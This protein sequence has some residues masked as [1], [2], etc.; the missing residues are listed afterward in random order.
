[1]ITKAEIAN[2]KG[3]DN[4][5]FYGKDGEIIDIKPYPYMSAKGGY[6]D[7]CGCDECIEEGEGKEMFET[8]EAEIGIIPVC[9]LNLLTEVK[10]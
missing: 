3:W 10:I 7:C 9:C 1:M 6:Q 4:H 2:T 8:Y 5:W